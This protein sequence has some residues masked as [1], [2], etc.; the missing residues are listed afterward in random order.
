MF[1]PV[2]A[3]QMTTPCNLYI[4]GQAANVNGA[5]QKTYVLAENP[6][7]NVNFST[8]G[9]T[10]MIASGVYTVVNTAKVVTWYR[11]DITSASRIERLE[12]GAMFEV[13][14]EPEDLEQRHQILSFTVKRLKGGV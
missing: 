8:Y 11:P 2:K 7:I 14:G 12:D 3:R 13:V 10:E 1:K 5:L 4:P 9:G 6:R